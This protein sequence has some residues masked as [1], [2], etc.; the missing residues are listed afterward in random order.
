[1]ASYDRLIPWASGGAL[2]LSV[3]FLERL[4]TC[5]ALHQRWLLGLSWLILGFSLLASL[6]SLYTSAKASIARIKVMDHEQ[7]AAS[8]M[9]D[10]SWQ[11][12]WVGLERARRAWNRATRLLNPA[13]GAL[14]ATGL[15]LLALFAYLNPPCPGAQT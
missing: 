14:L 15:L 13:A 5:A 11:H 4:L 1:M 10:S 2:F 6:A 3:T 8:E 12:Q 9:G 7:T